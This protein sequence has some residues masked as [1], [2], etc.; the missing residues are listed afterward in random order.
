MILGFFFVLFRSLLGAYN[1]EY[2]YY[3][4]L[5]TN[6]SN[7]DLLTIWLVFRLAPPIVTAILIGK[8]FTHF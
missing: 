7:K 6:F 3:Y 5:F 8:D 1:S 2:S 4:N